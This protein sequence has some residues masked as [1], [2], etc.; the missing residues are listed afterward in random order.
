M[1]RSLFIVKLKTVWHWFQ[2]TLVLA[3]KKNKLTNTEVRSK[4]KS[5]SVA[6]ILNHRRRI[7]LL[8]IEEKI[9][10]TVMTENR[11]ITYLDTKAVVVFSFDFIL[12]RHNL[13]WVGPKPNLPVQLSPCFYQILEKMLELYDDNFKEVTHGV[14]Q[15]MLEAPE[16]AVENVGNGILRKCHLP[17]QPRNQTPPMISKT[18]SNNHLIL[19]SDSGTSNELVTPPNFMQSNVVILVY[20]AACLEVQKQIK[21]MKKTSL[22]RIFENGHHNRSSVSS[23]ASINSNEVFPTDNEPFHNGMHN[24]NGNDFESSKRST[25]NYSLGNTNSHNVATSLN[26]HR[27]RRSTIGTDSVSCYEMTSRIH[28]MSVSS[29]STSELSGGLDR[30]NTIFVANKVSSFINRNMGY[31]IDHYGG[32]VS[33]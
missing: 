29:C 25:S 10:Y 27:D 3:I 9:K 15:E 22:S 26:N 8:A 18:R 2:F 28:G 1:S 14:D 7:R 11:R 30:S 23:H 12:R 19:T 13:N 20:F 5:N 24:E 16:V 33:Y 17:V 32:W 6:P 31:F 4:K 21:L